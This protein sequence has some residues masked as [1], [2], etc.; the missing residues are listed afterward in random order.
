MNTVLNGSTGHSSDT[1]KCTDDSSEN[2]Q[3]HQLSTLQPQYISSTEI[4]RQVD[5]QFASSRY[6]QNE[7]MLQ[8]IL[9][10]AVRELEEVSSPPLRPDSQDEWNMSSQPVPGVE[11]KLTRALTLI[12]TRRHTDRVEQNRHSDRHIGLHASRHARNEHA[13]QI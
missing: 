5:S 12:S 9:Q 7:Q 2:V 10:P 1:P 4:C 3:P 11:I 13:R 6:G 8:P